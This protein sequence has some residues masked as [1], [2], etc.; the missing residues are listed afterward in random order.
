[1]EKRGDGPGEVSRM[2]GRREIGMGAERGWEEREEGERKGEGVDEKEGR[3]GDVAGMEERPRARSTPRFYYCVHTSPRSTLPFRFSF[4]SLFCPIPCSKYYFCHMYAG[5]L[6]YYY[7]SRLDIFL[8]RER[9]IFS[10]L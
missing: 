7:T 2:R 9:D 4:L 8:R 6:M 3:V 10:K 1:M 5:I